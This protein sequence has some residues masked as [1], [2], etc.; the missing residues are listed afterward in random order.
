MYKR[1]IIIA[2][3]CL[4]AMSCDTLKLAINTKTPDGGRFYATSEVNL[5][6]DEGDDFFTA[7]GIK[8]GGEASMLAISI[9]TNKS[10]DSA[11]F[12]RGNTLTI[13]FEDGSEIVLKNILDSYM[14]TENKLVLK[15]TPVSGVVYSYYYTPWA[16]MLY[17]LP[18]QVAG[19]VPSPDIER[20]TA[21]YAL[22]IVSSEQIKAISSKVITKF[23]LQA[24]KHTFLMKSP[25][26]AGGIYSQLYDFLLEKTRKK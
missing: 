13:G 15:S 18:N 19:Y 16:G 25:E 2:G 26:E 12:G 24:K 23:E 3:L 17:T 7:M 4:V 5:F 11:M 10:S 9:S 6:A 22:Y 21:S 8:P 1:L 20:K 14:E